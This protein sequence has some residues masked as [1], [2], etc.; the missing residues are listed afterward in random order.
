[1]VIIVTL[2]CIQ[3]LG[4]GGLSQSSSGRAPP[5]ANVVSTSAQTLS[6]TGSGV[7]SQSSSEPKNPT[8]VIIPMFTQ[9]SLSEVDQIIQAKTTNL[10]A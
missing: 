10:V 3:A 5:G 8:G 7:V 6:Q 1:M 4:L 2:V 9:Y